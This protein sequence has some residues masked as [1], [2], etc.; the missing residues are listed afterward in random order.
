MISYR[1]DHFPPQ[2]RDSLS[3][4]VMRELV[5]HHLDNF[6]L[7]VTASGRDDTRRAVRNFQNQKVDGKKKKKMTLEEW[8]QYVELRRA[9]RRCVEAGGK[10]VEMKGVIER[11]IDEDEAVENM[12]EEREEKKQG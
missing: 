8:K 11:K 4:A 10:M 3:V 12:E 2:T 5:Y 1:Q 7:P 9:D 6:D